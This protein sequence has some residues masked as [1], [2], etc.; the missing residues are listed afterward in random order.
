MSS[1]MQPAGSVL[2]VTCYCIC[3]LHGRYIRQDLLNNFDHTRSSI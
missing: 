3:T 2:S 1:L